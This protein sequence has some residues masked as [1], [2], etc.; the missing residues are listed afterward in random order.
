VITEAIPDAN[1]GAQAL[2]RVR[3]LLREHVM[4]RAAW[5]PS[6]EDG[7]MGRA[8]SD[9]LLN[10][11]S[12]NP[13]PDD[14]PPDLARAE[15]ERRTLE[16]AGERVAQLSEQFALDATEVDILWL[17]LAPE[18]D[19]EFLGVYRL[20]WGDR[21]QR[22]CDE[23]FLFTTLQPVGITRPRSALDADRT[24][25]RLR[26][27][28]PVAPHGPSAT[29]Y[30]PAARLLSFIGGDDSPAADLLAW[31]EV[32]PPLAPAAWRGF[33]LGGAAADALSE[34]RDRH[35]LLVFEGPARAGARLLARQLYAPRRLP[36]LQLDLAGL[37]RD[38]D[39][40]ELFADDSRLLRSVLREARLL[41]ATIVLAGVEHLDKLAARHARQ[42]TSLLRAEVGP[43]VFVC[44]GPLPLAFVRGVVAELSPHH[45]RLTAPDGPERAAMWGHLLRLPVTDPLVR[46]LAPFPMGPEDMELA[47]SV[48]RNTG[49]ALASVCL[50]LAT[51]RLS[52]LA[53]R[54]QV[55]LTWSEVVLAP[56]IREQIEE[57]QTLGLNQE[58]LMRTWGLG[59]IAS[60][61]GIKLLFSGP[62]GTGKTLICGLLAKD[63]GRELYRIDLS[64]VVSKYIGETEK[65]LSRLFD[66]AQD[67]GV[68]LLFD[69]A[70]S[71]FASRSTEVRSS[72]DRYANQGVDFLLQ[73]LDTFDG[74]VILTTNLADAI[75]TAFTRRLNYE[76]RFE[77][78]G[79]TE[80]IALW[81]VHLPP[82]LP[83]APDAGIDKLARTY[84]LTGGQIRKAVLRAAV[85][86]VRRGA[87]AVGSADLEEAVR[88][89][90]VRRGKLP[91]PRI[92]P[93]PKPPPPP[94]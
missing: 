36:I 31:I 53:E 94:A 90:Y 62:S 6:V 15:E 89:E 8:L 38:A 26:L 45:V 35:R 33:T 54:V 41:Q 80:R 61:R 50:R 13:G 78:P 52:G 67:A 14:P 25:V 2:E 86:A 17:V 58:R 92:W 32:F 79:E 70:D 46:D 71:L 1:L 40:P 20:F 44:A 49:E 73:R 48:H 27:V 21:T 3:S 83:V 28:E 75:D 56:A 42:L 34:A 39:D 4:A 47:R 87:G 7:P 11:P 5:L 93:A 57:I 69:E 37:L 16:I 60:G 76:V 72:N 55:D 77:I 9:F 65:Q 59:R 30:R 64:S 51:T 22:W 66:E 18:L 63:M 10:I 74:L 29:C 19:Q 82:E 81:R 68:A 85:L 23:D 43:V 24:L 91:P 84:E 88:A 12:R